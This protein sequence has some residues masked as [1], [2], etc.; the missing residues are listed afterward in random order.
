MALVRE[1]RARNDVVFASIYVNPTQFGPNEDLDKYPRQLK[2]DIQM[3]EEV[4]VVGFISAE[5]KMVRC[6]EDKLQQP[7]HL[8]HLNLASVYR[9]IYLLLTTR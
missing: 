4:G 6:S 2:K 5:K 7:S 1:A 9:I 8:I 3:L